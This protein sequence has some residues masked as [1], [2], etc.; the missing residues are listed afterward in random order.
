M[1]VRVQIWESALDDV[2]SDFDAVAE[3]LGYKNGS[4]VRSRW[5]QIKQKK[6]I[7]ATGKAS[8]VNA[9]KRKV[10]K[11]DGNY[12]Q[13]DDETPLSKKGGK[14]KVERPEGVGIETKVKV[15]VEDTDDDM[16]TAGRI[17]EDKY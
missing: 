16:M 3:E 9:Q 14:M 10:G 17:G 5:N 1:L 2:Q 6:I 13:D 8:K 11:G 7:G 15:K 12:N 4:I